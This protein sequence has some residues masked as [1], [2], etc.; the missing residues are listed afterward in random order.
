MYERDFRM[1]Q[2]A[3]LNLICFPYIPFASSLV[4]Q[5]YNQ[6]STVFLKLFLKVALEGRF[7]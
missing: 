1:F 6:L 3:D 7:L 2:Q 4:D 5:I